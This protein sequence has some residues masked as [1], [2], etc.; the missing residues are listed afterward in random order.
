MTAAATRRLM[1]QT[2]MTK[3]ILPYV[4]PDSDASF[5]CNGSLIYIHN[6]RGRMH[7]YIGWTIAAF[8]IVFPL[9]R[10]FLPGTTWFV[11]DVPGTGGWFGLFLYLLL[12][13]SCIS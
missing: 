6:S 11:F 8:L 12:I 13:F 4:R 1:R 3:P 5:Q 7:A 2:D 10:R 9:V